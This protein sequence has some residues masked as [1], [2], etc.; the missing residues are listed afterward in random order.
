MKSG[1]SLHWYI[2]QAHDELHG[3]SLDMWGPR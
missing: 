1:A 2:G 3:I